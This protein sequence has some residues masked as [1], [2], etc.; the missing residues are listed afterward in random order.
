[1]HK[2][3]R[4]VG[5]LILVAS[6]L[7]ALAC[8]GAHIRLPTLPQVPAAQEAA[9]AARGEYLVRSVA[10]C[11]HCHAADAEKD[12]DGPLSGGLEFR[13]WRLGTIR[14]ANLTPDDATG[15][16]TWTEAEIVRALRNGQ[17]KDGRLLAPVM[18]YEWLHGMSDEDALAVAVYLKSLQPVRHAVKQSPSL[19]FRLAKALLLRPRPGVSATAP[20]RGAT[21]EYGEYL[22]LDVGLCADCHTPRKGLQSRPDRSRLF[23]GTADPPKGFPSNPS[24]LTP[25]DETGIGAWSEAEFLETMHTGVN[26]S[27]VHLDPFMP[28][29]QMGR[30]TDDDLRAIYRY[31]RTLPPI[32]NEVPRRRPS[33]R[34][35]GSR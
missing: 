29:R 32:H 8:A 12:P 18:P 17:S 28:W 21:A 19:V 35:A 30:M 13:N 33:R 7:L 24:N 3:K 23:A 22:A 26:P 5:T 34:E 11:G 9:I 14:A 6:A 1:M 31:L 25:D 16:G 10:A 27:G 4:R 15:L 20:P 2:E